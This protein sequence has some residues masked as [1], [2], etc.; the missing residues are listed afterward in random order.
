MT[1]Q[2]GPAS[3]AELLAD[4]MSRLENSPS[5]RLRQVTE[6]AVR[7]LHAFAAEV[8]LQRDEWFAGIQFLTAT[9]KMCDDIRQE[10]ILLSDTLGVSSLVEMLTYSASAG[11]TDNTVLGPF[12]VPGSPERAFG[13]SM[14]VDDDAGDRV[15]VRGRVTDVDGQPLVGVKIDAWQNATNRFYAC[16]QPGVQHPENLRG[17]YRSDPEGRYEIRTIRPVPY[18]IPDDGP[19]GQL[20][21]AN[22]RNWWRPGHLHLWVSQS[23]FKDLITHVFD[24]ASE[25]L[26][27]DAVF[28]VR[29]SLVRRFEPD[30]N[31]DLAT[32]FDVVLDR[33]GYQGADRYES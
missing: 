33:E 9:G 3:R 15:V 5:P 8:G 27:N 22:G 28:G 13:A 31:G 1:P 18:P 20:L 32:T 14:L 21:K 24:E 11:T 23:G 25:Y 7:H 17:V 2:S 19:A 6:A 29:P 12:Y 16:Q 26:T 4:V 10:F 30:A